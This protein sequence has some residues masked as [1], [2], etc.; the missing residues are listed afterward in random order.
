MR[1]L[2][3]ETNQGRESYS[4][5]SAEM[6]EGQAISSQYSQSLYDLATSTG[7]ATGEVD[8]LGNEIYALPDGTEVVIDARTK[9]AYSDVNTLEN[10][11]H[12][13]K[14]K[15]VD[16]AVNTANASRGLNNWVSQNNGRTIKI[17]GKYISPAGSQVP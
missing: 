12:G 4:S 1:Q 3:D 2:K 11:I 9:K 7:A 6:A 16:V 15:S 17:Y 8:G 13:V 5:L 14:G 10:K